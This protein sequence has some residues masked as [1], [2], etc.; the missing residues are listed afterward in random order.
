MAKILIIEDNPM[1][2]EIVEELLNQHLV[3][4]AE[5]G[6]D[7][8][9]FAEENPDLI[10]IDLH[11]PDMNGL[12]LVKILKSNNITKNIPVLAF[13]AAVMDSD[14]EKAFL[15][16][17]DGFISKPIEIKTFAE[18]VEKFLPTN[19]KPEKTINKQNSLPEKF[20]LDKVNL[21]YFQQRNMKIKKTMSK[22]HKILIVDDNKMNTELLE[23]IIFQI[24][25]NSSV[26]HSGKEALEII[27]NYKF[28]L[29]LLDIMMP[30]MSGFELLEYLKMS[31][32]TKD[33]PVIFISALN[34]V[35]D[36]VKGLDLGSHGY[37]TKPYNI[38]EVKARI[39]STLKIKDL[40]DEL[41]AEK[42]ILDLIF[43]FSADGVIML[44]SNMEI[45]S[46]NDRIV[47]WFANS[48]EDLLDKKICDILNC[49]ST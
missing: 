34:E 18:I 16:G 27:N 39:L 29:L 14:K 30:E 8:L 17:C 48:R 4:K 33:I 47:K 35:T 26:V 37:I 10:L 21:N 45:V 6:G 44:N 22:N 28:D 7:G 19:F 20:N 15:N 24:N 5:S 25:Q 1:D 43:K 42:N 3:L 2:I 38:D 9:R 41:K 31:P 49:H 40:Q 12:D 13:T 36:I 11:L 32:K 46:C 23:D